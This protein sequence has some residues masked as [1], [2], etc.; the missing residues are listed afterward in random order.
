MLKT[1]IFFALFTGQSWTLKGQAYKLC[2]AIQ[3]SFTRYLFHASEQVYYKDD[4]TSP[5]VL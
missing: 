1:N 2:Q 4:T 5:R 3:I